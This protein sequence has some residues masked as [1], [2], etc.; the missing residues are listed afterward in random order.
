ME[1]AVGHYMSVKMKKSDLPCNLVQLNTGGPQ[2]LTF[3]PVTV[4]R[5]ASN[6]VTKRTIQSRTKKLMGTDRNGEWGNCRSHGYSVLTS[7]EKLR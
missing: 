5:K 3:T 2:K 6:E 1:Q 7:C 4:P